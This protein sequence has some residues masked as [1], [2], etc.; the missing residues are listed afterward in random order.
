MSTVQKLAG[1]ERKAAIVEAAI[2]VF[3]EKGFRG[4]TT[5]EL[6]AAVGVSE[7]VLYQHFGTKGE[8]Y[9]AIIDS[10]SHDVEKVVADLASYLD[11]DDDRAFFRY[12]TELI[13]DF[14]ENDPAYLRLLLFSA[15]ERH[16]LSDLFAARHSCA[17]VEQVVRYIQR[18]IEQ[19]AI[20]PLNPLLVATSF[21]GMVAQHGMNRMLSTDK[22]FP[23]RREELVEGM[24]D[25]F[26]KGIANESR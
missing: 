10:K 22:R 7:P 17:F 20:R 14:H 12:L 13:L 24:V 1:R 4:T 5:R 18:R 9:A 6:A 26:L 16:E 11:T 21:L 19:G 8:L 23:L 25:I 3:S 2:K 15:L